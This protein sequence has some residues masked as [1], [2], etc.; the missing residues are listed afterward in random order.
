M[1]TI[2]GF[3]RYRVALMKAC[4]GGVAK[5]DL[6]RDLGSSDSRIRQLIKQAKA[7]TER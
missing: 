4:E 7:E 5:A 3:G 2:K 1:H 6:A